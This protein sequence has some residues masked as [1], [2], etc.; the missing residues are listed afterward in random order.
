MP[1]YRKKDIKY[2]LR[3]QKEILEN[4][5]EKARITGVSVAEY[6]RSAID[7]RLHAGKMKKE[8]DNDLHGK[9]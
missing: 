2:S 3:M 4:V 7:A 1:S 8:Q 9:G 6:V 5:K